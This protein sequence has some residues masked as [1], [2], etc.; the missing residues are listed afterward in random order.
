[1]SIINQVHIE[2]FKSLEN[3]T[4][5]LGHI[6][7][8]VG[9]NGSGKSNILEALGV[10]ASA[11][12]GRVD[13]NSLLRHG[14][15]P[16]MPSLY[17]CAFPGRRSPHIQFMAKQTIGENVE[18]KVT[19][20][21]PIKNPGESWLYHT[22][23]LGDRSNKTIVSRSHHNSRKTDNKIGLAALKAAESDTDDENF[24]FLRYLQQYVI[25]TPVSSILRGTIPD[26]QQ[27]S[28]VGLSG[29]R[30]PEAVHELLKARNSQDESSNE[31]TRIICRE[32]LMM[33]DWIRNYG[34][35]NA[36]DLIPKSVPTTA[37][38]IR[39]V[40]KYMH[41]KRNTLSGYDASEGALYVLFH[42]VLA[43]HPLAPRFYAVDNADHS[44]NPRLCRELFKHI[45]EWHL[46]SPLPHQILLTTHNP[47]ALDGLPLEDDRVRL[48]TV[49]R[50]NK[51]KTIVERVEWNNQLQ[52][53]S[54]KG[55][56]V[57]R[58]WTSGQLGGM[59]NGF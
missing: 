7:V 54:Q 47:L 38:V 37:K 53:M 23:K 13:D 50:S 58:L 17:K 6:N 31:R 20:F 4:I 59:P 56:T 55:W 15:R 2:A 16:G 44:L 39:F 30:L 8:F 40:D 27:L 24:L 52:Q 19:L 1:M 10:L 3:L 11:A 43:G 36:E 12:D 14:V 32:T 48:F 22:E 35:R 57:S 49:S 28:P 51:G 25:Y 46:S 33:I 34:I 41:E 45:C 9:A 21:N 18:Y 29:G 26:S 42:A 5:D